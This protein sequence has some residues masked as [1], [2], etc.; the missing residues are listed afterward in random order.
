MM[1]YIVYD[2]YNTTKALIA[3]MENREEAE[4]LKTTMEVLRINKNY[5]RIITIEEIDIF[6]SAKDAIQKNKILA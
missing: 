5:S 6:A 4:K 2:N 3:V 1:A